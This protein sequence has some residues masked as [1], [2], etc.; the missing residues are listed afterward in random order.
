MRSVGVG[1]G[2]EDA[3]QAGQAGGCRFLA[4]QG[5]ASR[6]LATLE[7]LAV[8]D[9]RRHQGNQGQELRDEDSVGLHD[10]ML[11][12]AERPHNGTMVRGR[13]PS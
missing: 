8:L 2:D 4:Q 10:A 9:G 11:P 12:P 5:V 7:H 1:V 13:R 3:H 6:Q